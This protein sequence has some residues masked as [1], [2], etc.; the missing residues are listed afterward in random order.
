[1]KT[2]LLK[3]CSNA[4]E[5]EM[6]KGMLAEE[7]I[8]CVLGNVTMSGYPPMSGVD[9]FVNEIDYYKASAMIKEKEYAEETKKAEDE[10]R[11]S[12][13]QALLTHAIYCAVGLPAVMFVFDIATGRSRPWN[14]Y[15]VQGLL[16]ALFM[17]AF[18]YF[19]IRRRLNKKNSK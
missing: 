12:M 1:M 4:V 6:L 7:G 13:A 17:T 19:E 3:N 16:F 5:A 2:R 10:E 14:L 15:L 11:A 9:V 8:E 18:R